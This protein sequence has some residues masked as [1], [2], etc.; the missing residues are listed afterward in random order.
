MSKAKRSQSATPGSCDR[1]QQSQFEELARFPFIGL[2]F[3][4][5]VAT[6]RMLLLNEFHVWYDYVPRSMAS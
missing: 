5:A 2:S 4:C 1:C 3:S 6:Y